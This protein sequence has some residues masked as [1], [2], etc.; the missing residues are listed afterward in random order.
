[1]T[2][3]L[4]LNPIPEVIL[5]NGA[6]AGLALPNFCYDVHDSN[7]KYAAHIIVRP[8]EIKRDN[9]DALHDKFD[10]KHENESV[11]KNALINIAEEASLKTAQE[12]LHDGRYEIMERSEEGDPPDIVVTLRHFV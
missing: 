12:V 7:G 9:I 11:I 8:P 1:M 3:E 6:I 4:I 10:I 5:P 2:K